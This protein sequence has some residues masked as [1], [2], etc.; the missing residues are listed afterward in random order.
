MLL[1]AWCVGMALGC[2]SHESEIICELPPPPATPISPESPESRPATKVSNT[3]PIT[4]REVY[5]GVVL[6]LA[7]R[8]VDLAATVVG[9]EVE[10]LEL[11][12]TRPGFRE[13]ESIVTLDA[14]AKHIQLALILLGLEPG[15][16]ARTER[17]AAGE[18]VFHPPHGPALELFFILNDRP[19]Q[20]VP[21]NHW[22]ADQETGEPMPD[23]AWRFTGSTVIEFK[24]Q[25]YFMAEKNGTVV[26][27]VNFGDDL[28]SRPTNDS[29]AGGNVFWTTNLNATP[30][31]P[32]PGTR[33][34][35]RIQPAGE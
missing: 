2:A 9:R 33:V 30:P 22:V 23:N 29:D 31:V 16:P 35:L 18:L 17:A 14:D 24:G 11:L 27:L 28:I 1:A 19:D 7:Q 26:S 10:W 13:H 34:T 5:P 8:H 3:N 15:Q 32:A 12:A 25:R 4:P 20:P 21:A 6:D